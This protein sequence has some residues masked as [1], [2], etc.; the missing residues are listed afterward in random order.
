MAMLWTRDEDGSWRSCAL[1][2]DPV[3]L[4]DALLAP[5]HALGR[6]DWVLI[7]SGED[8]VRIDGLPLPGGV[9]VLSDRSEI[10]LDGG[11]RMYYSTASIPRMEPFPAGVKR[12]DCP[13][14]RKPIRAGAEAVRCPSCGVWHHQTDEFPCWSY[15]TEC[16]SCAA[17]TALDGGAC[18][19]PEGL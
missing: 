15:S 7:E 13:R 9:R 12:L 18:W 3:R 8:R 4:A 16:A 1:E 10:R 14:C 11:I 6:E 17:A 19:T 2:G 5:M